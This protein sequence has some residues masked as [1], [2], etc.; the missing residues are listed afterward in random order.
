M[1][2][3]DCNNLVEFGNEAKIFAD[4]ICSFNDSFNAL[5]SLTD[6]SITSVDE[7]RY[8]IRSISN[9]DDDYIDPQIY[10]DSEKFNDLQKAHDYNCDVE[11]LLFLFWQKYCEYKRIESQI[12]ANSNEQNEN[13]KLENVTNEKNQIFD[14]IKK[15]I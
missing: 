7:A 12:N 13:N 1:N 6:T 2:S 11:I 9:V 4:K 15:Y 3:D 5:P 8:I 14:E 10:Y